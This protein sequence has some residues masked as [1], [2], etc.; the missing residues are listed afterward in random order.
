MTNKVYIMKRLLSYFNHSRLKIK[1]LYL[2]DFHG[3]RERDGKT[4]HSDRSPR[5]VEVERE[6][7]EI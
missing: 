3:K 7:N 4:S 2:S 6:K 1:F 5:F